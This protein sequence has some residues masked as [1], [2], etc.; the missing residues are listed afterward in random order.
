M[1]SNMEENR[2]FELELELRNMKEAF[3]EYV[4]SSQQLEDG[5]DSELADL[6]T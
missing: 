2:V 6:R 4:A 5:L 1:T 3:E